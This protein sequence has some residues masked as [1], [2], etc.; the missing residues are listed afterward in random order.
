MAER[1]SAMVEIAKKQMNEMRTAYFK[2]LSYLKEQ[3]HQKAD[4]RARGDDYEFVDLNL[5]D[6]AAYTFG[7]EAKQILQEKVELIQKEYHAQHQQVFAKYERRRSEL[8]EKL[9]THQLLLKKKSE[10]LDGLMKKHGYRSEV[11]LEHALNCPESP[12]ETSILPS[13]PRQVRKQSLWGLLR[14][15]SIVSQPVMSENEA[16]PKKSSL[17]KMRSVV[18]T[19]TTAKRMRARACA[20]CGKPCVNGGGLCSACLGVTSRS[21]Q[22]NGA[23]RTATVSNIAVQTEE[24]KVT[25]NQSVQSEIGGDVV[26]KALKE[27]FQNH[28]ESDWDR[29][30]NGIIKDDDDENDV[31]TGANPQQECKFISIGV[32]TTP[33]AAKPLKKIGHIKPESLILDDDVESDRPTSRTTIMEWTEERVSTATGSERTEER[34]SIGTESSMGS[35]TDNLQRHLSVSFDSMQPTRPSLQH[36]ST[37]SSEGASERNTPR[38]RVSVNG[39]PQRPAGRLASMSARTVASKAQPLVIKA[40]LPCE[41]INAPTNFGS[42]NLS[43]P[44]Q[45]LRRGRSN[46]AMA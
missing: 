41:G 10:L 7:D 13:A 15:R 12:E 39:V 31:N 9:G 8:A 37:W 22:E 46:S 18:H 4:A 16:P 44:S 45:L 40:P 32:Q 27:Y 43:R 38:R 42:F 17:T 36:R 35:A 33:Q 5:F 34:V 6:P 14:Q 28:A 11:T 25:S 23:I 19:I 29:I 26:E 1:E 24:R 2:E 3:L 30:L 21:S 20:S